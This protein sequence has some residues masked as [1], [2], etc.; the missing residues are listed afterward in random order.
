V[1]ADSQSGQEDRQFGEA[2]LG[3]A[4][5]ALYETDRSETQSRHAVPTTA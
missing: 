3:E 2:L 5:N 1:R 4:D